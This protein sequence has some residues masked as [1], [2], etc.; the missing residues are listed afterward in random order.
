VNFKNSRFEICILSKILL[1]AKFGLL[2]WRI[3]IMGKGGV[4]CT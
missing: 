4:F 3:L 1:F 2:W